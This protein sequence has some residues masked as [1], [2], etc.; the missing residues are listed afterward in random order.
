MEFDWDR[1]KAEL[2]WRNH[3]VRFEVATLVFQDQD[4][5]EEDDPEPSEYRL[6]AIGYANGRLLF[7]VFVIRDDVYRLI[8]AR[9]ADRRERRRYHEVARY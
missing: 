1:D 3:A 8:S 2:N 9:P 5:L 6:N 4:I 7:V